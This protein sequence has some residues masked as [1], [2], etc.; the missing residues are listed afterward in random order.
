MPSTIVLQCSKALAGRELTVAFVESATAGRLA[1]EFSMCPESGSV[2]KGGLVCYDASLK[3][4]I[5]HVPKDMLR[6]FTPESAE[7]TRELAERLQNFIPADIHVAVTGLTCPGGS[8]TPEKPVGTMFV[9]LCT[10][11]KSVAIRE[12]FSG[13]PEDIVLQCIDRIAELVFSEIPVASEQP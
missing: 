1:A 11:G 12:V 13:K 5:L 2:L 3:E 9:H 8:E 7:V 6:H 4:S 10:R